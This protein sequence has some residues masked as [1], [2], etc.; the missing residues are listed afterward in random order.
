MQ[1]DAVRK[2]LI[3]AEQKKV[4]AEQVTLLNMRI[5]GMENQ[6]NTLKQ[7]DAQT[8]KSYEDQ[9]VEIRNQRNTFE[10]Q[11]KELNKIIKKEKR[12]RKLTALA[13]LVTTGAAIFFL[14]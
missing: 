12:K 7:K 2:V 5:A 8:V 3:A 11:I 13:G 14:K 10:E 4:L 9:L 1:V 6:I